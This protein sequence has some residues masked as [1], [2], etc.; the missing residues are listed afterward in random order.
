M[1]SSSDS[2]INSGHASNILNSLISGGVDVRLLTTTP[3]YTDSETNLS[4][5]EI[6]TST[7]NYNPVTV[8]ESDWTVSTGVSFSDGATLE[9]SVEINFGE[10][11]QDWGTIEA[12]AVE[13][14]TNFILSVQPSDQV[15]EGTEVKIDPNAIT[16]TLGN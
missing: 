5:Y 10:A 14:G 11:A 2:G 15:V 8:P 3:N 13:D 12:I 6:D 7:T 4:G 9:N 16:Y 1:A